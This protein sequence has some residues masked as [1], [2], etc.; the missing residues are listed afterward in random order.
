[1]NENAK[2]AAAAAAQLS[3]ARETPVLLPADAPA[4]PTEAVIPGSTMDPNYKEPPHEAEFRQRY[5]EAPGFEDMMARINQLEAALRP[6]ARHAM[7]LAQARMLLVASGRPAEPAGGTWVNGTRQMQLQSCESIFFDAADAYG[8][9]KQ[10][11]E[12]FAKFQ[13]NQKAQEEQALR[14]AGIEAGTVRADH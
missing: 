4:N 12:L 8:R 1:M 7:L 5:A 6:F 3:T 9:G 10:E 13:E 11:A 2:R 14:D